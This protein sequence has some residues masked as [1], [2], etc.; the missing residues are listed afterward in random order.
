MPIFS[1]FQYFSDSLEKVIE[2]YF[3]HVAKPT[4]YR[5]L[6]EIRIRVIAL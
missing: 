6:E 3:N 4:E 1:I 2:N 5:M